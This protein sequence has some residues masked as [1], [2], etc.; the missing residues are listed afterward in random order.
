VNSPDVFALSS[1]SH[2]IV[3]GPHIYVSGVLGTVGPTIELAGGGMAAETAQALR[4]IEAILS[5]AGASLEDVVRTTVY[6]T[7]LGSFLEMDRAYSSL[8]TAPPARTTVYGCELP[9][10]AQIEIDAIAYRE[11]ER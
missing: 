1:F 6:L 2:A 8:F 5:Q 3:A 7:E 4:N 9:I 10:S 11:P